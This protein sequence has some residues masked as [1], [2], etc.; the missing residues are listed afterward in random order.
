MACV[1]VDREPAHDVEFSTYDQR[2]RMLKFWSVSDKVFG[3]R[4]LCL[5]SFCFSGSRFLLLNFFL[6]YTFVFVVFEIWG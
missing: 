3:L 1:W 5:S 6:N 4:I 2:S